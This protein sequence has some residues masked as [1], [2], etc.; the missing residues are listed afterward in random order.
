MNSLR[1]GTA[2]RAVV[3]DCV[4][5]SITATRR[6]SW[7]RPSRRDSTVRSSL[8]S[9]EGG[10]PSIVVGSSSYCLGTIQ[11]STLLFALL[12]G[13]CGRIGYESHQPSLDAEPDA[14]S[15]DGSAE[16]DAGLDS[17]VDAAVDS[18]VDAGLDA[19]PDA[20]ADAAIDA[21][22]DART[23]L[24]EIG[25]YPAGVP[26]VE[27]TMPCPPSCP[28]ATFSAICNFGRCAALPR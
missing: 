26:C 20:P 5:V 7:C 14:V 4:F 18:G 11:A 24:M 3:S 16:I 25:E 10:T 2:V 23:C 27:G 12:C 1:D 6:L 9:S 15:L 28:E 13:G 22:R 8:R 21:G 17:G 19:A